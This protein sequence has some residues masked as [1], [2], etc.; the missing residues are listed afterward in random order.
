MQDSLGSFGKTG[1]SL[2]SQT[3]RIL[4]RIAKNH[5]KSLSTMEISKM[6]QVDSKIVRAYLVNLEK[7]GY[8]VRAQ[9][10][11]RWTLKD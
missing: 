9:E 5:G 4:L 11:G 8:A 6:I 2:V 10:R 1:S 7:R 3:I